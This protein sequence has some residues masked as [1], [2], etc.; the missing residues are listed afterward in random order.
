[1]ARITVNFGEIPS[2]T[3]PEGEHEAVITGVTMR[4][5]QTGTHPYLNWEFQIV[6]GEHEGRKVWMMTSLAP[7]ALFRLRDTFVALGFSSD[8]VIELDVDEENTLVEPSVI[9]LPVRIQTTLEKYQ[10]QDRARVQRIVEAHAEVGSGQYSEA[11]TFAPP[12]SDTET[13]SGEPEEVLTEDG[14]ARRT[15]L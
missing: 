4:Q 3:V 12:W 2:D 5:S 9:G 15:L 10:G 1:M 6:E 14:E 7:N 8:A 11:N 13:A